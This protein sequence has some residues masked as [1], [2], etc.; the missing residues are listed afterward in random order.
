MILEVT[1]AT[2]LDGYNLKLVFNHTI[3]R[4]VD[5]SHELDGEIFVPLHDMDYFKSF[6]IDCGT[7]SWKNGADIAPEYLFFISQKVGEKVSED[8]VEMENKVSGL[9]SLG[10]VG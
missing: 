9:Y 2:Y 8:E 3:E 4:V 5:L 10:N 7:I 1:H 6:F